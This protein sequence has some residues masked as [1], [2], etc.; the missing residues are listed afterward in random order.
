MYDNLAYFSN[1]RT[2]SSSSLKITILL[3]IR[4]T[5]EKRVNLD[6]CLKLFTDLQHKFCLQIVCAISRVVRAINIPDD[7]RTRMNIL[8]IY[9]R[10]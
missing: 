1:D 5:S 2:R 10:P 3:N 7:K 8:E 6:Y 4:D 9:L